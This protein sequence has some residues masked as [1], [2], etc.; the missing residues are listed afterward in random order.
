MTVLVI[1][2]PSGGD[3]SV[4][5]SRTSR[6]KSLA[7]PWTESLFRGSFGVASLP[8]FT[9]SG[10]VCRMIRKQDMRPQ[11]KR[12][13]F[14]SPSHALHVIDLTGH[15]VCNSICNSLMLRFLHRL[16]FVNV[17][18]R[19]TQNRS[20]PAGLDA[21]PLPDSGPTFACFHWVLGACLLCKASYRSLIVL[22]SLRG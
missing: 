10:T 16:G 1:V 9:S 4:A 21:L 17:S 3:P 6:K 14:P 7:L 20:L 15:T 12:S 18:C 11:C 5:Y 2:R 8:S 13:Q 22:R 19:A